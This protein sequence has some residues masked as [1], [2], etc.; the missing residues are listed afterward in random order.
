M[1]P[2]RGVTAGGLWDH[3]EAVSGGMGAGGGPRAA[4]CSFGIPAGR[5]HLQA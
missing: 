2:L 4:R 5:V 1:S 3:P